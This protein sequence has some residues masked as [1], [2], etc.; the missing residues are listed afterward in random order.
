MREKTRRAALLCRQVC[1]GQRHRTAS[2]LNRTRKSQFATP[3]LTFSRRLRY[4]RII[5]SALQVDLGTTGLTPEM[6]TR[7]RLIIHTLSCGRMYP[8]LNKIKLDTAGPHHKQLVKNVTSVYM[9]IVLADEFLFADKERTLMNVAFINSKHIQNHHAILAPYTGGMT[10]LIKSLKISSSTAFLQ[11]L[12]EHAKAVD[13]LVGHCIHKA[14]QKKSREDKNVLALLMGSVNDVLKL[15][16]HSAPL[17]DRPSDTEDPTLPEKSKMC[18]EIYECYFP[19]FSFT[20]L[21]PL[22]VDRERKNS[23]VFQEQYLKAIE[24]RM[25][26]RK[27][28]GTL[29]RHLAVLNKTRPYTEKIIEGVF[30][31]DNA[32]RKGN[33]HAIYTLCSKLFLLRLSIRQPAVKKYSSLVPRLL[34]FL[35]NDTPQS[36]LVTAHAL[37]VKLVKEPSL[38]AATSYAMYLNECLPVRSVPGGGKKLAMYPKLLATQPILLLQHFTMNIRAICQKMEEWDTDL[39]AMSEGESKMFTSDEHPSGVGLV[40]YTAEALKQLTLTMTMQE[41]F[42]GVTYQVVSKKRRLYINALVNLL[43]CLNADVLTHVC[44]A[45]ETVFSSLSDIKEVTFWLG[46]TSKAIKNSEN[47]STKQQVVAW[48]LRLQSLLSPE[49]LG[50]RAKL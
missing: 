44:A 40:L 27:L 7:A 1:L 6:D 5:Q 22:P 36:V 20:S 45:L 8:T 15:L 48:F 19:A 33:R 4:G 37:I 38:A 11:S 41:S 46:Y 35:R 12:W 17:T 39:S 23:K 49:K 16:S 24:K 32:M 29:Q 2:S 14:M 26:F 21:P 9:G 18:V 3:W 47:P 43:Q 42:S 28:E 25:T 10:K 31:A 50:I 13:A 34:R 30:M